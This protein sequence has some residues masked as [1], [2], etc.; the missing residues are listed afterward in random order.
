MLTPFAYLVNPPFLYGPFAPGFSIPDLNYGALSTNAYIYRL[1]DPAGSYPGSPYYSDVRDVA[2]A[3]VAALT[4]PPESS[5]GRKRILIASPYDFNFQGIVE[6]IAANRP[7]LKNRLVTAKPP[8]FPSYKLPVDLKRVE[9]VLGIKL[10]SYK[11]WE[12]TI[13]DAVD[14]LVELEKDWKA[15]GY[16]VVI[17]KA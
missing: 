14:S 15:K 13:L 3:H 2:R 16:D 4:S 8:V 10:D 11:K 6:L 12:D 5:V 17:P 7:E 9:D 1:L